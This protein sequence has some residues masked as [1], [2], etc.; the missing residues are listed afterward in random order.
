[1][2]LRL[3]FNPH[4]MAEVSGE[5]DSWNYTMRF[6]S[7]YY[8]QGDSTTHWECYSVQYHGADFLREGGNVPSDHVLQTV[9]KRAKLAVLD[10]MRDY[11]L[12]VRV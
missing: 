9:S 4:A 7:H 11:P 3:Y 12:E 8:N 2:T 1:M 5:F 10:L 6:S